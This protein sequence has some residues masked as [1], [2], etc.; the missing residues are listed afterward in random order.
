MDQRSNKQRL[1]AVVPPPPLSDRTLV[2]APYGTGA[3]VSVSGGVVV[4][5]SEWV[6][7]VVGVLLEGGVVVLGGVGV[8]VVVA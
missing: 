4:G 8:V 5:G 7:L 2:R 3:I 1:Q 6:V